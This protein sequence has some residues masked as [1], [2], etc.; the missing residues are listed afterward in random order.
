MDQKLSKKADLPEFK[1]PP[2]TEVVLGVEFDPLLQ[3]KSAHAGRYWGTVAARYPNTEQQPPL[4][5]SIEKFGN[6]FWEVQTV[7]L[8][9]FDPEAVRHWFISADN[10][11]LVQL[12]R[13]RFISNWRKSSAETEYPRY[14]GAL[15]QRFADEYTHFKSFLRDSRLGE[16]TVRQC[17]V[18]YVNDVPAGAGWNDFEDA[19]HLTSSWQ[20]K[21]TDGFLG[22]PSNLSIAAA[23]DMPDELGRLHYSFQRLR[24]IT[25]QME[26]IQ[27]SLTARGKP[28]SSSIEHIMSWMDRGREWVVKGFADLTSDKAH[29][30]WGR[31]S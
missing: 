23:Y 1:K 25:D 29:K 14:D 6:A 22:V 2:V 27:F 3:F 5:S 18:T 8:A 20:C 17:E 21:G 12:Q 30:L 13:D 10:N 31:V 15:R 11:F 26:V 4:L 19:L 7:R 9:M 16:P 28:E 24:R